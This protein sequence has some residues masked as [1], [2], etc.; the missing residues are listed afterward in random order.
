[1]AEN[2]RW[3][4]NE[5]IRLWEK[6]NGKIDYVLSAPPPAEEKKVYSIATIRDISESYI[7]V[8]HILDRWHN[9]I[10]KGRTDLIKTHQIMKLKRDEADKEL[11]DNILNHKYEK[12]G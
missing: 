5:K 1:M 9:Q 7:E 11:V 3:S 2:I 4:Y 8:N 12:V 10:T 6:E